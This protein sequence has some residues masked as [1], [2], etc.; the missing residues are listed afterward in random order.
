MKESEVQGLLELK[1][2][3]ESKLEEIKE[4]QDLRSE[5]QRKAMELLRSTVRARGI[6]PEGEMLAPGAT[7]I[8]QCGFCTV[9]VTA[10]TG[11]IA[12]VAV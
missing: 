1:V 12:H 2:E 4:Y 9:C 3:Y 8:S 5:F 7:L 10:C 11:C 6:K